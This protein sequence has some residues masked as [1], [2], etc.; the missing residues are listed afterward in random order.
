M[1]TRL[2]LPSS[3]AAPPISPAFASSWTT[4]SSADRLMA[5]LIP[6]GTAMTTKTVSLSGSGDFPTYLFRQYLLGPLAAQTV[7]GTIAGQA[8]A[9][10]ASTSVNAVPTII[11]RIV[12][13]DGATV[14]GTLVDGP[15]DLATTE[16]ATTLTN[17]FLVGSSSVAVSS[18]AASA[19]DYLVVEVGMMRVFGGSGNGSISFG[20]DS[21]SDLPQNETATAADNPWVEFSALTLATTA[22]ATYC[23]LMV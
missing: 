22:A 7:S 12:S 8:R 19:G 13:A 2:Y 4:T 3:S 6:T 20:D 18:V 16:A 14:R 17:R 11:V 15:N 21:G 9:S 10:E 5:S 23:Y 1:A